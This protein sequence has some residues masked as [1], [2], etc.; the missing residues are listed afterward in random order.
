[1]KLIFMGLKNISKKW[2]MPIRDW[3]VAL[4]Q[5]AIIYGED[6]SPYDLLFTQK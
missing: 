6:E 4:N 3:V 2:T 1:M 5:F